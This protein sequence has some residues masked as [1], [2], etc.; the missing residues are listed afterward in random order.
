MCEGIPKWSLGGNHAHLSEG[1]FSFHGVDLGIVTWNVSTLGTVN[2]KIRGAR[3]SQIKQLVARF[4]IVCLQEVR[5]SQTQLNFLFG[6]G[7]WLIHGFEAHGVGCTAFVI[8]RKWLGKK[9][10]RVEEV[11]AGRVSRLQ[12]FDDN[13][14]MRVWC[15]HNYGLEDAEVQRISTLIE[16]DFNLSLIHI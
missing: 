8:N 13:C 12:I 15:I 11:S 10:S 7:P 3:V 14:C 6:D 9:S 16:A 1:F 2:K 4:P 5:V